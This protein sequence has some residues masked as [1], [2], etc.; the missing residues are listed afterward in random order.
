MPQW[1]DTDGLIRSCLAIG[2]ACLSPLFAQ[3]SVS[4]AHR[5]MLRAASFRCEW[6]TLMK[7]PQFLHCHLS[8]SLLLIHLSPVFLLSNFHLTG[9]LSFKD[10]ATR[11]P[12]PQPIIS[13]PYETILLLFVSSPEIHLFPSRETDRAECK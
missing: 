1:W 10:N 9:R 7:P 2:C 11:F 4:A 6:K 5:F 12:L 3:G 13:A 8:A